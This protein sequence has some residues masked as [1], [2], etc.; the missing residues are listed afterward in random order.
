MRLF[1]LVIF[2]TLFFACTDFE[3]SKQLKQVN[4]LHKNLDSLS[5]VLSQINDSQL[6]EEIEKNRDLISDLTM[7]ATNDTLTET[8]AKMLDNYANF[9]SKLSFLKTRMEELKNTLE[10]QKSIVNHLKND[11]E[12]GSGKR[13]LYNDQIKFEQRKQTIIENEINSIKTKKTK[14]MDKTATFKLKTRELT[15]KL[16]SKEL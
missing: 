6:T 16:E 14:I 1:V 5:I 13:H 11:I 8:E 7:S 9:A 2:S 15:Q 3:Q 4:S 12:N 10:E